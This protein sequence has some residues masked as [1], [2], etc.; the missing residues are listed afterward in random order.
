MYTICVFDVIYSMSCSNDTLYHMYFT[1]YACDPH[2]I[3]LILYAYTLIHC[4]AYIHIHA[5]YTL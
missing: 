5:I 1:R 2:T 3:Y 4:I